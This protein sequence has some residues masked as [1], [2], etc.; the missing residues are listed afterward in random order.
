MVSLEQLEELAARI[1]QLETTFSDESTAAATAATAVGGHGSRRAGVDNRAL[2]RPISFN[3][4]DVTWRD[5]SVGFTTHSEPADPVALAHSLQV[6]ETILAASLNLYHLVPHLTAG[7]AFDKVVTS[8][9]GEGLRAW[10]LLA[11]RWSPMLR[12]RSAGILLELTRFDFAGDLLSK[13]EECER[14]VPTFHKMHGETVSSAIQLGM[15][16]NRLR[17]SEFATRLV[18]NAECLK[19]WHN[20]KTEEVNCCGRRSLHFGREDSGTQPMDVVAVSQGTGK[21]RGTNHDSVTNCWKP[22]PL[23]KTVG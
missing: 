23:R 5:W 11:S 1:V 22:G 13:M 4:E 19:E 16:L 12:S 10:H 14:A 2:G 7:P 15:V 17:D 3:G 8:G 6:D 18:V 20:I 9:D 21:G